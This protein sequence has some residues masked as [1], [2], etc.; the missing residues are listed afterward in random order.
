MCHVQNGNWY[1]HGNW[2][3]IYG[4]HLEWNESDVFT[5][6]IDWARPRPQTL[7][8]LALVLAGTLEEYFLFMGGTEVAEYFGAKMSDLQNRIF[9]LIDAHEAYL[10]GK[11][12]PEI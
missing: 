11:S 5:P 2:A 12:W 7:T 1:V 8:T 3:D 4:N 10:G 6:K 9:T